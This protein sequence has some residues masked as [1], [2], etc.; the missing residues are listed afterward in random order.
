MET[1]S[2]KM[3]DA[4]SPDDPIAVWV[5]NLS[6]A[7]GDLRIVATYATREEQPE[8]ERIYFVR[9]FSS[10]LREISKLLVLDFNKRQDIRDFVAGLPQEAQ[11]ARD[12]TDT[13]LHS[14]FALRPDVVVWEDLKRLRDDTFHYVS[15]QPSQARLVDA[16]RTVAGMRDG[17]MESSYVLDDEGWLR[18]EYA[19]LVVA[20]R[21]HPFPQEHE[22]D[23]ELPVTSELH[24][25]IVKLNGLIAR[26]LAAAE[27]HY[28]LNVVEPGVVDHHRYE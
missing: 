13:L 1:L 3:A 24:E 25:T 16:M 10:H 20:N 23:T 8:Y 26:F 14:T 19:D 18:A 15:D 7:L 6:I 9:I 11:D 2:F 27:S 17:K 12:E 22:D 5:M 28:L 4:F 21:M